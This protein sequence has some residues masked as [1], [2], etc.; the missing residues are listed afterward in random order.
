MAVSVGVIIPAFRRVESLLTTLR[1]V[2]ACHPRPAEVL[3]WVNEGVGAMAAT[4]DAV[5][6]AFGS[7]VKVFRSVENLGPGGARHAMLQRATVPWVASFDDDS[8]PLDEDYF[9][10]IEAIAEAFPEA[11]LHFS[12]ID[13]ATV[14]APVFTAPGPC[15]A[16][17]F[18][19]CGCVYRRSAYLR[20]AGY[21]PLPLAYGC[22]ESD[23]SLQLVA[24][25]GRLLFHPGLRVRHEA[26]LSRHG[27][28]AVN[29]ASLQNLAL[30][31]FLRYPVMAW[32]LAV[33]QVANRALYLMRR[34]RRAGLLAGL[35]GIPALCWRHRARRQPVPWAALAQ[36]RALIREPIPVR[37]AGGGGEG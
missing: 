4:A 11:D 37:A 7:D 27:S 17:G 26:D 35:W 28:A 33:S 9:G 23:V 6:A 31:A 34:G 20:L 19:G 24:G 14:G 25:G 3:V 36:W 16:G 10:R 22:E 18:V 13:E 29:C 30:L 1:V 15:W 32:P 21:V 2:L 5:E 12:A 8:F